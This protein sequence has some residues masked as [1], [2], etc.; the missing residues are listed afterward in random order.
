[1]REKEEHPGRWLCSD[2]WRQEFET[3][4]RR[5]EAI[6]GRSEEEATISIWV[7]WLEQTR[8]YILQLEADLVGVRI[9]NNMLAEDKKQL[10]AE[11]TRLFH[12]LEET[13]SLNDYEKLEA[14]RD[15]WLE[16]YKASIA[17]IAQLKAQVETLST[18]PKV[19]HD[20]YLACE[21]ENKQLKARIAELEAPP[22]TPEEQ[23]CVDACVRA[24]E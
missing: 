6:P 16:L 9:A 7:Q 24:M 11:N 22:L 18:G 8:D 1:M 23:E 19:W 15:M 4:K 13:V 2:A 20:Q 12:K 5:A 3:A 17:E 10:E 14:E 21:E